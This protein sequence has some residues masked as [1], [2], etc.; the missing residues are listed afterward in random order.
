[1]S[2][3]R[4]F[5]ALLMTCAFALSGAPPAGAQ[6]DRGWWVV[7][8]SV[9]AP[10]N[11]V[12]AEADAAIRKI[13]A[14]ARR[15]GLAPFQDFSSKFGGFSRGYRVVVSGAYTTRAAADADAAKAVRCIDGVYVRQ[16]AY[17]GD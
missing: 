5:C 13:E 9:S 11:N 3:M 10:D 6:N 8:G 12:S 16:G 1:M 2:S 4:M 15:C 14:A 17:A 7:L